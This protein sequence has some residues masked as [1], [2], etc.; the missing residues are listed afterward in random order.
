M[1]LPEYKESRESSGKK[2][3]YSISPGMESSVLPVVQSSDEE[4]KHNLEKL[5]EQI[6]AEGRKGK[7]ATSQIGLPMKGITRKKE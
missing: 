7:R 2:G 5:K 6:L 1:Y 3:H 4:W